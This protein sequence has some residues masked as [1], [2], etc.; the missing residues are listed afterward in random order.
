MMTLNNVIVLGV[1]VP[2]QTKNN[3]KTACVAAYHHDLGLIRLYPARPDGDLRRWAIVDV[4]VERPAANKDSRKESFKILGP[5]E[6]QQY[7]K[8]GE[9]SDRIARAELMDR[10]SLKSCQRHL[11]DD[12]RSLA[13]IKPSEIDRWHFAP[14]PNYGTQNIQTQIAYSDCDYVQTK[15]DYQNVPRIKY[16]CHA[17]CKGHHQQVLEWGAFECIR[18]NGH[19]NQESLWKNWRIGDAN[20]SHYFL[21]GNQVAHRATFLVINIIPIETRI[22]K[23][24]AAQME[25]F[26]P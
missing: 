22:R 19:Q 20:Y 2:E 6:D 14:N 12:H 1:A 9:L 13:V 15:A 26:Q 8:V 7:K 25:L 11:N 21:I 17:D 18:K 16:K 4:D 24:A 23:I 3:G 10:L 5:L